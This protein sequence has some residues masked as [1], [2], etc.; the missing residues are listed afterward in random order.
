MSDYLV[1]QQKQL[2][3]SGEYTAYF[4]SLF[5]DDLIP[6][7][8]LSHPSAASLALRDQ[9]EAWLREISPGARIHPTARLDMDLV[10]LHYSFNMG[11]QIS[12]MYRATNVGFGIT[13]IL[14]VIVAMLASP[15]GTLLLIENPEAHLH[16]KGQACMGDLLARAA[17]AGVQV[18]VETHSDHV[19]NGI[20]LAVRHGR[21]GPDHARLHFSAGRRGAD[22]RMRLCRPASITTGASLPGRT[23]SSISGTKAWKLCSNRGHVTRHGPRDGFE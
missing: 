10:G 15:A 12:N 5:G 6:N 11:T 19:L 21:L 3:P 23:T 9:V 7:T 4:L 14:P 22:R 17:N 20:R 2:G 8:T 18:V 13:Y 1:R 16:P